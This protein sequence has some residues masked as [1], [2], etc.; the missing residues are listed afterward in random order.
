[1]VQLQEKQM[2]L[3]IEIPTVAL[4]RKEIYIVNTEP[5]ETRKGLKARLE[6]NHRPYLRRYKPFWIP[7]SCEW[8]QYV[9]EKTWHCHNPKSSH[10]GLN[11][12]PRSVCSH[13]QLN[14]G[15]VLYLKSRWWKQ[16]HESFNRVV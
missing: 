11:V 14:Q 16:E 10:Y 6:K 7:I 13:W 4:S 8:C 5:E 3:E 9:G 2:K 12:S 15:L 1:M